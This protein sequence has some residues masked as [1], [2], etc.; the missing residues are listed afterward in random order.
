MGQLDGKV[1]VVTGGSKGIGFATAQRF[2]E[3]GAH[4]YLTGRGKTELDAAV[5]QIGSIPS[6]SAARPKCS[7]SA[8]AM[9]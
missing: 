1:A 2:A 6:R 9:K 3:E 8:T 4:V 7:C 5:A